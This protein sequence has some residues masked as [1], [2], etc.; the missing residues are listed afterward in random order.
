MLVYGLPPTT[1]SP[2]DPGLPQGKSLSES[3]KGGKGQSNHIYHSNLG[4][5]ITVAAYRGWGAWTPMAIW[6]ELGGQEG[7]IKDEV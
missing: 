5:Y 6:I 3:W 1:P 4:E 7:D 2:G